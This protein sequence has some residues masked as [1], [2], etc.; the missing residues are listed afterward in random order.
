MSEESP[1]S[2]NL[3]VFLDLEFTGLHR[4]STP[5]SVALVVEDG[6]TYY[7]EFTDF[8]KYQITEFIETQVLSKLTIE[9]FDLYTDYEPNEDNIRV[10]GNTQLVQETLTEFI[11]KYS[12][13]NLEF[14]MDCPV[15]TWS[16]F[17][18]II[19]GLKNLP[20]NIERLPYDLHTACKLF[21]YDTRGDRR[22]ILPNY[23]ELIVEGENNSLNDA[24]ISL[25]IFK[26]LL[27]GVSS[28]EE[29]D[30]EDNN[31]SD[32]AKSPTDLD[33]IE[34]EQG[35]NV[36]QPTVVFKTLK[37]LL[38]GEQNTRKVLPKSYQK[39]NI[40][41]FGETENILT[42]HN[43]FKTAVEVVSIIV[44]GF[45]NVKSMHPNENEKV[46]KAHI[47]EIEFI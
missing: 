20:K 5:I 32:Y 17:L 19:G 8:D 9:T 36:E 24:R 21:G 42:R 46:F 28:E 1:K 26:K 31:E 30:K 2:K 7:A 12:Q 37:T 38:S 13:N 29:E 15:F 33:L 25:E 41:F 27:E 10:K 18:D 44:N 22:S 45:V 14:W 34:A 23:D 3:K 43:N 11:A 39:E 47:D 16:I 40:V 4:L 35:Y 6:K